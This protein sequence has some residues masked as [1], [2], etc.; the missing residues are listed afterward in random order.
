MT[1]R[2]TP[3]MDAAPR[4]ES[5]TAALCQV[6]GNAEGNRSHEAR[7]MM[8]GLRDRFTYL[9]CAGCGCLQLVDPPETWDRYYPPAYYAFETPVR[10]G[11]VRRVLRAGRA[12]HLRGERSL[13]GRLLCVYSRG[14]PLA[15]WAVR[16]GVDR[17]DAILDVGSGLGHLLLTMRDQGFADLTGIDPFV[18][19]DLEY[20]GGVR[21]LRRSLAEHRVDH[22]NSYDLVMMHH[23]FEHMADPAGVLRDVAALV[24]PNRFVVVRLPVADT[25]GWRSYGVDW[26]QLDAPRHLFLHTR[27]SIELLASAAGL[28][29]VDVSY[30]SDAFLFWGSEAYRRDLALREYRSRG[31]GGGIHS[32]T[33]LRVFS[34][35]AAALN[36][37]GDGDQAV[38][39]LRRPS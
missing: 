36:A 7:E 13:V 8:F 21:V 30:D 26:A 37:R 39:L 10:A 16:S 14:L 17:R 4:R 33:D 1:M 18:E 2:A 32:E 20:E 22:A 23:S 28:E 19:R 15:G 5:P 25:Y 3:A 12:R 31:P 29:V 38:F 27:R 11:T 6:C 34:A 9:E 35:A 24:R